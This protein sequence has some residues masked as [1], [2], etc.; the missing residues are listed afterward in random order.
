MERWLITQNGH[1]RT[2]SRRVSSPVA[3]TYRH[4]CRWCDARHRSPRCGF[5]ADCHSRH[6]VDVA[7]A[8]R[9]GARC[10][11]LE[12]TI[13]KLRSSCECRF[14]SPVPE[15]PTSGSAPASSAQPRRAHRPRVRYPRSD[16]AAAGPYVRLHFLQ[17]DPGAI[18][19]DRNRRA[20]LRQLRDPASTSYRS[21]TP[22]C[23]TRGRGID[24]DD[25]GVVGSTGVLPRGGISRAGATPINGKALPLARRAFPAASMIPAWCRHR[26]P[27][28]APFAISVS[29][30]NMANSWRWW[31]S[32][33]SRRRRSGIRTR[34]PYPGSG[35]QRRE[36]RIFSR[37]A[38]ETSN[39]RG[40]PAFVC[41]RDRNGRTA[42]RVEA[43]TGGA[44]MRRQ[45]IWS[46]PR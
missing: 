23:R 9:H 12:H 24:G 3:T 40:R 30:S 5:V 20:S 21:W 36:L 18:G 42:S 43:R 26:R 34:R 31:S 44:V 11:R 10:S 29:A 22:R 2:A 15:A 46:Y 13:R 39:T 32:L 37:P 33:I 41:A 4:E 8:M 27:V 19:D 45:L 6:S 25:I 16:R 7:A 14:L 35:D 1:R 38:F 17:G 28:R